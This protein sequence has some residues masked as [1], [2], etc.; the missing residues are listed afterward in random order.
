MDLHGTSGVA[1][2]YPRPRA[3]SDIPS[4]ADM[5]P[6]VEATA[7][8]ISMRRRVITSVVVIVAALVLGVGGFRRLAALREHSQRS[9]EGATPPLVRAEIA[10]RTDHV[11]MLRGYGRAEALQRATVTAEVAGVVREVSER[12]EAGTA[13]LPEAEPSDRGGAA[14]AGMTRL[15]ILLRLDARDLTDRLEQARD[16]VRAAE[17]EIARLD[18]LKGTLRERLA[19]AEEERA[20]AERELDRIEPLVPKTLTRSDLDA[21][22]LQVTV[23]RRATLQLSAQI[24]ENEESV[25]VA[26]AR[27]AGL[28]RAITLAERQVE[29]TRVRAPFAGRIE[30][31]LVGLG[32]RV[33]VGD[34]L[35]TIVDLSRMQVPVALPAGRYGEVR[36]GAKAR[37]R[38]PTQADWIWQGTVARLAPRINAEE[39]TFFAFLVVDGE[40]TTTTT[41][42]AAHVVA[43]IEGRTHKGVFVVP[44][45]AFLGTQM[46]V[47][48]RDPDDHRIFVV[49]E[50]R[51]TVL[52]YLSGLALVTDGLQEGERYLVTNLEAV[53]EGSRVRL[54]TTRGAAAPTPP[55]TRGKK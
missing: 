20:T 3:G 21:Q 10:H 53:A 31:R 26:Q 37:V 8:P 19:V 45:R 15:P 38:R 43:E 24:K 50:R 13:I 42:P 6:P 27:L 46:F 16:E 41:P 32:E 47:A 11:E 52:R 18:I 5:V 44:R 39:R 54:V 4:G 23:R 12:L 29:R 48:K 25:K 33:R 34:P 36:V 49:S 55:P 2:S 9:P 17:A 1:R 51:P 30:E 40:P 22:R 28:R 14:E 7:R 35:F